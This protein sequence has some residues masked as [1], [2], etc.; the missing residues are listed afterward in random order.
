MSTALTEESLSGRE[1]H[2]RVCASAVLFL[3]F[4]DWRTMVYSE[5]RD[6]ESERRAASP[7]LMKETEPTCHD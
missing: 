1:A 7:P 6:A 2:L 3:Y 4:I 5:V